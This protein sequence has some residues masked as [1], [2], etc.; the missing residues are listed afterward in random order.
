MS[1]IVS[2][3]IWL[4]FSVSGGA[5]SLFNG[6]EARSGSVRD[7]ASQLGAQELARFVAGQLLHEDDRDG[8]LVRGQGVPDSIN[9]NTRRGGDKLG[10]GRSISASS[11]KNA[12]EPRSSDNAY[13]NS[14]PRPR[15]LS[16]VPAAS[17]ISSPA[18][19]STTSA[20]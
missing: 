8:N 10:P 5:S 12:P 3:P 17:P 9:P 19:L 13:L 20:L 1:V 15:N 4:R 7:C 11:D 6:C 18:R 14:D 2:R 16:A